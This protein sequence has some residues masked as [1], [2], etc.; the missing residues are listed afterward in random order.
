MKAAYANVMKYV[1]I[2]VA[3]KLQERSADNYFQYF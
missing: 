1:K 3:E 2:A